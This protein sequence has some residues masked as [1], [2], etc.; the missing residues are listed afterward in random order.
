MNEQDTTTPIKSFGLPLH[1]YEN[2]E[3]LVQLLTV[4]FRTKFTKRQAV[5]FAIGDMVKTLELEMGAD[6]GR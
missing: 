6:N 3:K 4:K 1:D 5:G 2:A